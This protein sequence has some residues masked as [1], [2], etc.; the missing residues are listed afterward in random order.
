MK[1]EVTNSATG[2]EKAY[3]LNFTLNGEYVSIIDCISQIEDDSTLGFKIE[4]FKMVQADD[5]TIQA[6]FTVKNVTI[7]NIDTTTVQE[8]NTN[9]N[10][11][12]NTTT[13]SNNTTNT[14][15]NTTNNTL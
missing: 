11:T 9:T 2:A 12:N 8:E 1:L 10:T 4:N 15:N 14:M 13:N 3:N 5:G 7:D 6:T